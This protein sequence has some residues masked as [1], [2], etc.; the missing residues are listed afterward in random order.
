MIIQILSSLFEEGY[1]KDYNILSPFFAGANVAFRRQTLRELGSYNE[2]CLTGEDHDMCLRIASAGWGLYF[3]PGAI[4]RHKNKMSLRSFARKWFD[5]GFYHPYLFKKHA[6]KGLRLYMA[7]RRRKGQSPQRSLLGVKFPF[8]VHIFLTSFLIMHLILALSIVLAV[9]G[10]PIPAG[11]GGVIA[12]AMM[13]LYFRSDVSRNVF[14]TA[15]FIFFRYAANVALMLGGLLGG[16][17]LRMFYISA[18]FDYAG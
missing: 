10:L 15:A 3:T 6:A 8:D 9:V 16:A 7:S 2:E 12:L 11:I 13:V 5:Y 17:R 14:R 18:T 1:L 4:V